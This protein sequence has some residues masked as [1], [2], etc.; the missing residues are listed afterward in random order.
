MI[1]FERNE[2][3]LNIVS[4]NDGKYFA[5]MTGSKDNEKVE[6]IH[7]FDSAGFNIIKKTYLG[8]KF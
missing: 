2:T 4:S 7:I 5:V 6:S 1:R 8:D 3:I